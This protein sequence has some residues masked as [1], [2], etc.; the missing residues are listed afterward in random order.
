MLSI[1]LSIVFAILT[2]LLLIQILRF[3]L[4]LIL[5]ILHYWAYIKREDIIKPS[6]NEVHNQIILLGIIFIFWYYLDNLVLLC[7]DCHCYWHQ[8]EASDF[9]LWVEQTRTFLRKMLE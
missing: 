3:T 6:I 4:S 2:G 5:H 9:F 1:I 7:E 8:N